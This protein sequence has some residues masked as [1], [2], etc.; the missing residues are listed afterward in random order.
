MHCKQDEELAVIFT[1]KGQHKG[2]HDT[3]PVDDLVFQTDLDRWKEAPMDSPHFFCITNF[4]Y[5]ASI[6]KRYVSSE[7][8]NF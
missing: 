4:S 5:F 7:L 2:N 1:Q 3:R 8:L 6:P